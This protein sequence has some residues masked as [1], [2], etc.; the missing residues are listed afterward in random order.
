MSDNEIGEVWEGVGY[1]V[2][3]PHE[4]YISVTKEASDYR[5][6]ELGYMGKYD[7][8]LVQTLAYGASHFM[9]G[10][11]AKDSLIKDFQVPQT[12]FTDIEE[13]ERSVRYHDNIRNY[14]ETLDM[15]LYTG[16]TPLAK[17]TSVLYTLLKEEEELNKKGNDGGE[18]DM[19]KF[20]DRSKEEM[21]KAKES[22]E[23][24]LIERL[25]MNKSLASMEINPKGYS[26]ERLVYEMDKP[27]IK[28][29]KSLSMVKS[30]DKLSFHK[31]AFEWERKPMRNYSDVVNL[32]PQSQRFRPDYGIKFAKKQLIVR[33]KVASERQALVLAIDNSGS[34]ND[35]DKKM[36]VKTYLTHM[37]DAVANGEGEVYICWF[38]S[39][40]DDKNVVKVSTREEAIAY[41]EKGFLG[42]FN[43]GGTN[44]GYSIDQ[45]SKAFNSGKFGPH[46][47]GDRFNPQLVI[48]NDGNDTV[49]PNY[50]SP[51]VTHAVVLGMDNQEL[52]Q[53]VTS[54]GGDYQ[55]YL[56]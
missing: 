16:S 45:I 11:Q 54:S 24:R 27:Q 46:E 5:F 49:D 17:A 56:L 41:F 42:N 19:M 18:G 10:N 30:K 14:I 52:K 47:I 35:P 43:M 53:L 29:M 1:Q 48:I 7:F 22:I 23:Q 37:L 33:N 13:Y 25:E 55:R 12:D 3:Y 15:G 36:W 40:V 21:G 26:M 38:E 34:M 6:R 50:V 4:S 39:S 28:M 8:G 51:F 44:V 31:K 9:K 20:F 32:S 2:A